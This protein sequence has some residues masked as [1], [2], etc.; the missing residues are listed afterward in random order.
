MLTK[1]EEDQARAAALQLICEYLSDEWRNKL[2]EELSMKEED[3]IGS[4]GKKRKAAT[5]DNTDDDSIEGKSDSQSQWSG[6]DDAVDKMLQ[7]TRGIDGCGGA[8]G[9][10]D[11]IALDEE[12]REKAKKKEEKLNAKSVGLKKLAK[13]NT[14][15]MKSLS[16]FFGAAKKK[17]KV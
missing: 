4:R 2:I 14:K 12:E 17:K 15:G 6:G 10:E 16:S 8:A 9:N 3:L 1:E 7:I 13:V 5:S 11:A